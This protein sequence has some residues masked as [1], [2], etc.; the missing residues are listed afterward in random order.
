M[1]PVEYDVHGVVGV[2]LVNARAS[3]IAA[4]DRQLGPLRCSLA[5]EPEIVIRYVPELPARHAQQIE[6]GRTR[7]TH[8][9][10]CVLS[11]GSRG[12]LM[13]LALD[14][15][16]G[17]CEIVCE[18]G[19][20]AVPLLMP[21]VNL[22]AL[23]RGFV[24]VH[25]AAVLYNGTGVL[26]PAWA[27]GG[28]TT[29]MLAFAAHGAEYVGDEWILV[30]RDGSRMHGIPQ[31]IEIHDWQIR[32]IPSMRR[33]VSRTMQM[34]CTAA[35]LLGQATGLDAAEA[36]RGLSLRALHRV[37]AAIR[38]SLDV[39]LDPLRLATGN[40]PAFSATLNT[41]FFMVRHGG[42]DIR[43]QRAQPLHVVNSIVAS[44]GCESTPL[45]TT[46][47]KYRSAFPGRTNHWLE[48]AHEMRSEFLAHALGQKDAFVVY[49]PARCNLRE[50]FDA[51]ASVCSMTVAVSDENRLGA[52]PAA[53]PVA[54]REAS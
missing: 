52:V 12:A 13:S 40:R 32:Q 44:T 53:N 5:R 45:M 28:K 20:G 29:A 48:R 51:M 4:V 21:I 47:L 34:A 15:V 39:S 22:T 7:F 43:V 41:I 42:T 9:G 2:R 11:G 26:M 24:A 36:P 49:H 46:Y 31:P 8:D 14:A 50:L 33:E 38:R 25:A 16:G 23:A 10:L 27:H 19:V 18:H 30:S 54:C 1:N 35:R 6:A 37:L 17:A 3:D